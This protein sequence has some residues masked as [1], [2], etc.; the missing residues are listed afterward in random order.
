MPRTH[1]TPTTIALAVIAGTVLIGIDMTIVNIAIPTLSEDTGAA[2]PVIQWGITGYTLALAAA[3]PATAWAINR[4]GARQVF[5]SSL[6]LFTLGSALVASSGN[7]QSLIAFRVLQGLGGGL[8]V[9][10]A[11]SVVLVLLLDTTTPAWLLVTLWTVIA[12]GAGCTIMPS[13]TVA[14]RALQGPQI[15]SG[16]TIMSLIS[17]VCGA[18]CVAAVSVLLATQLFTRLPGVADGGVGALYGQA[19]GELTV[20]APQVAAAVQAT[21]WLPVVLIGAALVVAL[22]TLRGVPAPQ[23]APRPP[24]PEPRSLDG[25]SG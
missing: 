10:T 25:A 5:L 21:F 1:A 24:A 18:V 20:L 6:G 11:A 16:S 3:A 4:F 2:L 14:T 13:T 22:A 8:T 19:P 7:V 23:P 9:A 15:P 12:F 17:Q